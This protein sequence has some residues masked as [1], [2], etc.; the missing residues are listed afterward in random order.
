MSTLKSDLDLV[1]AAMFNKQAS[2]EEY[3]PA[4]EAFSRIKAAINEL[5]WA[6]LDLD[7]WEPWNRVPNEEP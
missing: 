4:Y 6:T 7:S 3:R 2:Y 1:E 5:D